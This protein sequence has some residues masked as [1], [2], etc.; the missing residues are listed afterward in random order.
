MQERGTEVELFLDVADEQFA[1]LAE[2]G[3]D[4]RPFTLVEDVGDQLVEPGQLPG[5]SGET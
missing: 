3:E 2:L 5:T 4:E 1:H